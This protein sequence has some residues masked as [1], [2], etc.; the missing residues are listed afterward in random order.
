MPTKDS[1]DGGRGQRWNWCDYNCADYGE[2]I[3]S[4]TGRESW[5]DPEQRRS[6]IF[7]LCSKRIKPPPRI[8]PGYGL[9]HWGALYQRVIP[10]AH[11]FAFRVAL[12]LFCGLRRGVQR[13][14]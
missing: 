1:H 7:V 8:V 3:K 5:R 2:G 12:F 6:S 4:D 11:H 9:D 10:F 13:F 14:R